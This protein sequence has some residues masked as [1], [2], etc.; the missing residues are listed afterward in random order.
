M[1]KEW[2]ANNNGEIKHTKHG[3]ES[4]LAA[5][6]AIQLLY[7]VNPSTMRYVLIVKF[8][9]ESGYTTKAIQEKIFKGTWT[10]GKEYKRAGDGRILIDIEGF[11]RWVERGQA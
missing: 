10:E 2:K 4:T 9:S 1:L 3:S 6:S 7:I 11:N 8:A 5:N